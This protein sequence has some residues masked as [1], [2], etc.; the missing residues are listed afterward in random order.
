MRSNLYV[1]IWILLA[2]CSHDSSIRETKEPE[3]DFESTLEDY[4]KYR[5]KTFFRT[6]QQFIALDDFGTPDE[7]LQI[8]DTLEAYYEDKVGIASAYTIECAAREKY[9]ELADSND[10][11]RALGSDKAQIRFMAYR[12]LKQKFPKQLNPERLKLL[13]QDTFE[14][15][16]FSGCS[17]LCLPLNSFIK[18]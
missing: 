5:L 17:N 11:I 1:L 16:Y 10:L 18:D 9:F 13:K 2:S 8:L 7:L 6:P 14:V 15:C 4:R 12:G 3:F